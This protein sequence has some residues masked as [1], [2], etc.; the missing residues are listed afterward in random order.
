MPAGSGSFRH[1]VF[2]CPSFFGRPVPGL[3][4][5]CLGFSCPALGLAASAVHRIG[6]SGRRSVLVPRVRAWTYYIFRETLSRHCGLTR[7]LSH[8]SSC[9][10]SLAFR[11][12]GCEF[13]FSSSAVCR[14]RCSALGFLWPP[15]ESEQSIAAVVAVLT[16][17]W[18]RATRCCELAGT[19]AGLS[20]SL[21]RNGANSPTR[22]RYPVSE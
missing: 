15:G 22:Q 5:G 2:P 21:Q 11:W 17:F 6:L 12:V 3:T 10:P 7:Q 14:G 19:A 13:C 18:L 8:C 16:R 9:V 4:D 1:A 20:Q